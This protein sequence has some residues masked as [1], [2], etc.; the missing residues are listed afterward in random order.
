MITLRLRIISIAIHVLLFPQGAA[1]F[2]YNLK[3]T[4][5]NNKLTR[6]AGCP[7]LVGEK[8]GMSASLMFEF[9]TLTTLPRVYDYRVLKSGVKASRNS[10][11]SQRHEMYCHDLEVMSSN[12]GRVELGVLSA[13]VLSCT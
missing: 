10:L 8:W 4:M 5:E 12:P 1:A 7:V 11:L 9:K 3:P 2:W 6:H 13:S